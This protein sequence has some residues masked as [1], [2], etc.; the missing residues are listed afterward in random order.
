[1]STTD[2]ADE[3]LR[4]YAKVS[5]FPDLTK[6]DIYVKANSWFVET[7]KSAESVI[8]FSDKEGGKIMGRYLFSYSEGIYFYDIKQIIEVDIQEGRVRFKISDPVFNISGDALNGTYPRAANYTPLKSTAGITKARE[9]WER[10]NQDFLDYLS[11]DT[12]W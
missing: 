4:T 9:E 12:S 7:F 3:S 1:M 6:A 10:L 2:L 8:E 5:E 11:K